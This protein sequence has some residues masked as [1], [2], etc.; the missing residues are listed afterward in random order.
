M[1]IPIQFQF[2][3]W[4]FQF[5]SNSGQTGKSQ[6]NSNSN[7]GIGIGIGKQFQFRTGIGPSSDAC[8]HVC[9]SAH[10]PTLQCESAL[11]CA[12]RERVSHPPTFPLPISLPRWKV[13]A[14][15]PYRTSLQPTGC[16]H[17]FQSVIFIIFRS[18]TTLDLRVM[19]NV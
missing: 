12:H 1:A 8:T 13:P 17:C 4:Q 5:N 6:F 16:V 15:S 10:V 18:L 2:K 9:M 14:V 7:S 19:C 11:P 3:Y